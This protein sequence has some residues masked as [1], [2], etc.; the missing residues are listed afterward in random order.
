MRFLAFV[1]A[2]A[3]LSG[4]HHDQAEAAGS[5]EMTCSPMSFD[6]TGNG[7]RCENAEAICYRTDDGH[8]S[9]FAKAK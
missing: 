4:C 6:A 1:F 3:A 7:F 9:C 8:L 2:L 5:Y